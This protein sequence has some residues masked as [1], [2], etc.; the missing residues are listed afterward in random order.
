MSFRFP[1][2]KAKEK[3]PGILRPTQESVNTGENLTGYIG[4]K[5]AS[6][7]EERFARAVGKIGLNF[8]FQWRVAT[9]YTLPDQQKNVDFVVT[10]TDGRVVPVEVYGSYFHTSAGDRVRDNA[11]EREL[12]TVFERWGWEKLVVIWDYQL[13]NQEVADSTARRLFV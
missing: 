10:Q 11:R 4:D 6:D 2:R 5:K 3:L 12:D 8:A 9:E 13:Y 7:L 1:T